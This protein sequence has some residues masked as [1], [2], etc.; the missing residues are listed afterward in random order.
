MK[1]EGVQVFRIKTFIHRGSD[2][3]SHVL[4][5]LFKFEFI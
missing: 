1:G 5:N 4:L 3:S 2:M